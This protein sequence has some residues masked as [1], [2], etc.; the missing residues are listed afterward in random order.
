MITLA[1]MLLAAT[2]V[3]T[4]APAPAPPQ[5]DREAA[6][7][8]LRGYHAALAAGQAD[9]VTELLGPSY[10]MADERPAKGAERL[11]AHLFL[12]GERLRSWPK[13]YLS[14][15]GPHQNQFAVVAVSIRG[16]AAVVV[17]RDT[18]R[19]SFRAWSDEET[20]WFLGRVNGAWRIVG[21]VIRDI[22]LPQ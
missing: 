7:S 1:A 4:P 22:Q 8:A 19:N 15:A 18:G 13:N 3:P 16:D 20:A 6:V 2:M 10:F 12:D 11:G 9:K 17:T 5:G 21:M 14:Q